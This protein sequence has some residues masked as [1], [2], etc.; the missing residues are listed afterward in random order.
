MEKQIFR[1]K[2]CLFYT[3]VYDGKDCFLNDVL[4]VFVFDLF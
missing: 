2:W 3:I 1:M 4:T